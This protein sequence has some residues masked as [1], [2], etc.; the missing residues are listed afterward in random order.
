MG[1]NGRLCLERHTNEAKGS[2]QNRIDPFA[3]FACQTTDNCNKSYFANFENLYEID[4]NSYNN[5]FFT[6]VVKGKRKFILAKK[7]VGVSSTFTF[8]SGYG[9]SS[10]LF[11]Q[12]YI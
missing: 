7:D 8:E 9:S 10:T 11:I 4:E 3:S 12:Q 2:I 6:L 1:V 5:N